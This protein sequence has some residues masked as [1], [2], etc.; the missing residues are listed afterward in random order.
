MRS[1]YG[2][3]DV[4]GVLLLVFLHDQAVHNPEHNGLGEKQITLVYLRDQNTK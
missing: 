2:S 3:I 1:F 4:Y